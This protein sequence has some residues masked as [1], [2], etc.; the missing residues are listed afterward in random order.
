[1]KNII[2]FILTGT[3]MVMA[4]SAVATESKLAEL[5]AAARAE[6]V[7]NSVGMP[8]A[9]AN[10][11]DTW[12]QLNEKYGIKH[13]DTDMSSGEEIA[14]FAN[15]GRS[16]TADI[17]DVGLE[18][19]PI[20][21]ARGVTLPFKP[22]T[23]E[24]IPDWAKE[25]DGHWVLGYTGTIAFLVASNIKNPP[26]T[27]ADLLNGD[28]KVSIHNV[29]SGAMS[30]VAVLAASIANGGDETN[31]RPGVELFAKLAAQKRLLSNAVLPATMEKGEIQVAPMWDFNALNYRNI[32]GKH[33]YNIIIPKDGS[34]TSGY[35]TIINKHSK[36]PN[37]AKFTREYILSDAGQI[38]LARGHARPIR[39]EHLTLPE[40]I[41]DKLLP[42]EE[43]A[44]ARPINA[45]KWNT[46]SA[47]QIVRLWR[48]LVAP[49]L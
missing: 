16:A 28:Y 49:H 26:T 41:K 11:K 4:S 18:F 17:G 35:A 38:N 15:E 3:A 37:A 34:V 36:R 42:A 21:I 30:N 14:K 40:D 32:V 7:V 12:Q 19:G 27:W 33:K 5:E 20:A 2:A 25:K 24:Q 1:M 46:Q 8:D 10:W 13:T 29:G 22:S 9:W 45:E 23:W 47:T 44:S 48:E 39:F 6:G 43:Y 31:L